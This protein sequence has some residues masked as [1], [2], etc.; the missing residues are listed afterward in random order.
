MIGRVNDVP[1]RVP[2]GTK[3]RD[4][5]TPRVHQKRTA[6]VKFDVGVTPDA[7]MVRETKRVNPGL[8]HG[9]NG[10]YVIPEDSE[11][12]KDHFLIDREHDRFLRRRT[13]RDRIGR[14]LEPAFDDDREVFFDEHVV[15]ARVREI[16]RMLGGIDI[17][18]KTRAAAR[19]MLEVS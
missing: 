17:T 7:D 4:L 12:R 9:K 6:V 5:G 16:A 11:G 10:G 13:E 3:R 15:K 1:V 8:R 2:Q 19:E 18:E 14:Q